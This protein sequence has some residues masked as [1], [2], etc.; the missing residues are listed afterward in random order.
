V[1]QAAEAKKAYAIAYHSDMSKYGP[2]AHL[3]AVTHQ[4]G[5]YYTKA[6]QAFESGPPPRTT[7]ERYRVSLNGGSLP[8][9][10]RDGKELY[11][12]GG[13]GKLMAVDVGSGAKFQA[14]APKF[15]FDARTPG[16][17]LTW[18]DV[19][20]DGHFL[21]PVQLE[22]AANA[23]MTVVVNWTAALKK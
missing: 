18:F 21:I 14:G 9:W 6:V 19:S 8:R 13:D 22:Q 1:V 3:T 7:G 5:A 15:L 12:I 11:F 10:R 23:P 17:T 2:N 20:K 4:W 16:S